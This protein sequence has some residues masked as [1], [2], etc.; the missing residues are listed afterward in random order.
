M[1]PEKKKTLSGGEV[2]KIRKKTVLGSRMGD[3]NFMNY[4]EKETKAKLSHFL[5]GNMVKRQKWEKKGLYGSCDYGLVGGK[6]RKG[7]TV[8]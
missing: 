2:R 3:S 5:H 1:K 8:P 6:E 4:S 7:M